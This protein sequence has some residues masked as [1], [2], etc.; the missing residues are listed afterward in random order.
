MKTLNPTLRWI[1]PHVTVCNYFT[2]FWTFLADHLSDE[3]ATGTLQRI[4]VKMA[5]LLQ[6]NSM[7]TFGAPYPANGGTIDPVQHALSGDAAA[8]HDQIYNAAVD[9]N[10][11][12]DCESGQRGYVERAA[13]GY[14]ANLKIAVDTRTPGAQGP[15]YKGR[16]RVPAGES[17]SSEPGGIAPPLP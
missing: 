6:E 12:A 1:G 8:F 4:Q 15:T 11:N 16:P 17:F 7:A 9:A 2:Y 14:P 13:T 3:E 10:G 5:P